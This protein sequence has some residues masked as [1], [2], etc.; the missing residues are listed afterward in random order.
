MSPLLYVGPNSI[1]YHSSRILDRLCCSSSE[2]KIV[3]NH[4]CLLGRRHEKSYPPSMLFVKTF[5]PRY[6]MSRIARLSHHN[7]A[8][9]EAHGGGNGSYSR[10]QETN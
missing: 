9:A 10:D 4:A 1:R 8:E 2:L 3:Y 6:Q 5:R 7:Y